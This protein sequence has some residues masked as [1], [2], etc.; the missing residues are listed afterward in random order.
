MSENPSAPP[1]R[2][3]CRSSCAVRALVFH[4]ALVLAAPAAL[5]PLLSEPQAL[6][7]HHGRAPTP[8]PDP[9][10]WTKAPLAGA[11]A[12]YGYLAD[13]L[14]GLPEVTRGLSAFRFHLL[15]D[16]PNDGVV[17]AGSLIFNAPWSPGHVHPHVIPRRACGRADDDLPWFDELLA[18]S[19]RLH[20]ALSAPDRR[21]SFLIVPGKPVLYADRL[22]V[23]MDPELRASCLRAMGPD[24]PLEPWAKALQAEGITALYPKARLFAERDR[25]HFYP[26]ENFHTEGMAAHFAAW[27]LLERLHPGR[28]T[29]GSVPFS[30]VERNAD[31]GPLMGF[32]L[33]I[34]VMRPDY[35]P[36]EPRRAH[37]RERYIGNAVS[38]VPHQRWLRIWRNLAPGAS[39][40]MLTISNSFGHYVPQ[41]LA[42]AYE[43]VV[44]VVLNVFAAEEIPGLLAPLIDEVR[45]DEIAIIVNDA[46][47]VRF[48]FSRIA[49]GL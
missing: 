6:W 18:N 23:A 45:P 17:R 21:V 13:R 20:A 8:L 4:V 49:H 48:S 39:G 35:G 47:A 32:D 5:G 25:P 46:Y 24:N 38:T 41:H 2:P 27:A 12:T 9:E 33:S 26:P 22:P 29:A 19:R 40:R 43:Q 10:L 36:H 34:T 28:F 42:P 15:G 1:H 37:D 14:A 30:P 31:M 7:R 11:K 3:G 44:A 16:P